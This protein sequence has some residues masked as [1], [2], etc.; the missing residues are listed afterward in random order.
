[1]AARLGQQASLQFTSL[2]NDLRNTVLDCITK[3][4]HGQLSL[5][6]V[7]SFQGQLLFNFQNLKPIS[8]MFDVVTDSIGEVI[9]STPP[10]KMERPE[11]ISTNVVNEQRRTENKLD[12]S[13]NHK[14]PIILTGEHKQ[15]N[16][17]DDLLV[18]SDNTEILTTGCM[19]L[20]HLNEASDQI[21]G[22]IGLIEYTDV[23]PNDEIQEG[24]SLEDD[25]PDDEDWGGDELPDDAIPDNEVAD[26]S[27]LTHS[28]SV[29]RKTTPTMSDDETFTS[30]HVRNE[31]KE[32]KSRTARKKGC[33]KTSAKEP[34]I[35]K[36]GK[37]G[38]FVCRNGCGKAYVHTTARNKHEI[39][40]DHVTDRKY[41]CDQCKKTFV[42]KADLPRH[43][44]AVHSTTFT[45][46]MC[47][48]SSRN[49]ENIRDHQ[50][51]CQW[52]CS[53]CQKTYPCKK[54][55]DYHEKVTCFAKKSNSVFVL[56][57]YHFV[58]ENEYFPHFEY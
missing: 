10:V 23:M 58:N 50:Q 7:T 22:H 55:R 35:K 42:R 51:F 41:A 26:P 39:G 43:I 25:I 44:S 28:P 27:W 12:A 1:M 52:K 34:T 40:P 53:I 13:K 45:C 6:K 20:E 47:G 21:Q 19:K 37:K 17:G 38:P 36:Q 46:S 54:Y 18:G 16:D 57:S 9:G 14:S 49:P 30:N 11:N 31:T 5:Y 33:S 56:Q 32:S 8:I 48:F 3:L 4:S 15:L 2:E 29:K 24:T